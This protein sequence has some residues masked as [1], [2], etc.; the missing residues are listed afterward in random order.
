M[1]L[2]EVMGSV[3]WACDVLAIS[4]ESSETATHL[5]VLLGGLLPLLGHGAGPDGAGKH[6]RESEHGEGSADDTGREEE[7]V[8]A[9]IRR[10]GSAGTVGAKS[11]VVCCRERSGQ[12]NVLIDGLR[13]FR[14]GFAS[15]PRAIPG[16]WTKTRVR[17]VSARSFAS[18][19]SGVYTPAFFSC[20]V[21]SFQSTFMRSL[22]D[23]HKSACS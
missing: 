10:R 20:I 12:Q 16:P 8:A 1:P 5:Q 21:I 18:R 3:P 11:D 4:N 17:H 14:D 2:N 22:S 13:A 19:P 23:I 15:V 9:L 7:D 6:A